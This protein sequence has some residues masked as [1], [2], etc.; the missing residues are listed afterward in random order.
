MTTLRNLSTSIFIKAAAI[1]GSAMTIIAAVLLIE[2]I[3][4]KRNSAVATVATLATNVTSLIAESASVQLNSGNSDALQMAMDD[5]LSASGVKATAAMAIDAEG[6]VLVSAGTIAAP[7]QTIET[8][9]ASYSQN[10]LILVEPAFL[11]DENTFVGMI[12]TSWSTAPILQAIKSELIL[13]VSTTAILLI[14]LVAGAMYLFRRMI[15]APLLS[16]SAEMETVAKGTLDCQITSLGRTDEIGKIAKSLDQFRRQLQ[17]A[18]KQNREMLFQGA[19]L[20]Q[21]SAA[22]I[23]TDA[24]F[25]ITFANPEFQRV[26]ESFSKEITGQ[27][28]PFDPKDL[29]GKKIDTFH[30]IPGLSPDELDVKSLPFTTD[31]HIGKTIISVSVNTVKDK[32]NAHVGYVLEWKDVTADRRN[33]AVITALEAKQV[34]LQFSTAWHFE[35]GNDK[36]LKLIS[37]PKD[38]LGSATF[39]TLIKPSDTNFADIETTLWNGEAH[40]GRFELMH[41]DGR[42]TLLDGN[43]SSI[44]DASH[45][46]MG[47]VFMGLDITDQDA[48]LQ[49][50]KDKRD[51]MQSQLQTVVDA[52]RDTLARLADGDLTA[53][54]QDKFAPEYEHLREDYNCAVGRLHDA[55]TSVVQQ[56]LSIRG[57][58]G[59]ISSAADDLSR[60]TEHQAATLEE[61]A[62]ALAQITTSVGSTAEGAKRAN[63]V[64]S[65][66]RANAERSGQVVKEAV[67]AMGEISESS[68]QISQIIRVID[69]IAFQTNLLALNAGVEAARAGDAGRGFAVVASEVRALAQRSS[70]AAREINQLISAS[71]QHVERGVTLVGNAGDALE[72]I[73]QSVSNI[74]DHVARITSSAEEQSHGIEEVNAAVTQLDQVTQQN[75]AMFEETTAASFA[76]AGA[77]EKLTMEMARFTVSEDHAQPVPAQNEETEFRSNRAEIG[78]PVL[79]ATGTDG[80]PMLDT[81]I[82]DDWDEF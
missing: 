46:P 82:N 64:V 3:Y 40:F 16:L 67:E 70:D 13:A 52:L 36:F 39:H 75:A 68:E 10:G 45:T 20:E 9:E 72:H 62:A 54:I 17:R 8:K 35:A 77:A 28:A 73:V 60:R 71:S 56:S 65:D 44:L 26:S 15:S 42:K 48:K 50:A 7:D 21:C 38:S 32:D 81:E 25:N 61:T 69:D 14:V 78:R 51:A 5:I 27:D 22:I 4:I 11:G 49:A 2:S 29:I 41:T 74:S 57:E 59:D 58:V 23:M 66:A 79:V 76:L 47:Y 63:D 19:A 18:E 34:T 43:L 12:A 1:V 33:S 80:I 24:D 6:R 55:M 53:T 30:T 31:L 37:R